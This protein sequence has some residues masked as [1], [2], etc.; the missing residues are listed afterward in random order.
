MLSSFPTGE[1]ALN[2]AGDVAFSGILEIGT[3]AAGQVVTSGNQHAVFGPTAGAGSPLGVVARGGDAALVPGGALFSSFDEGAVALNNHGTTAFLARLRTEPGG[4]SIG[5]GDAAI[6]AVDSAIDAEPRL[7]F[8]SGESAPG[9]SD[10]AEFTFFSLLTLNDAGDVA[11][12]AGLDPADRG[13]FAPLAG[14]GSPVLATPIP[15]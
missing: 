5:S 13:V 7:L 6:F 1:L 9:A 4:T 14:A 10:G 2:D 8:R 3:G 11:F 15:A 12:R